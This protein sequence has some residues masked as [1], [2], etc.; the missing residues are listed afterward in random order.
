M[1]G[2]NANDNK[3]KVRTGR[4]LLF[5]QG[6][7]RRTPANPLARRN[8]PQNRRD[9]VRSSHS[10]SRRSPPPAAQVCRLP[11]RQVLQGSAAKSVE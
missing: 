6:V 7:I 4:P 3:A 5:A 8:R 10:A 2:F 1:A 9:S 11:Q